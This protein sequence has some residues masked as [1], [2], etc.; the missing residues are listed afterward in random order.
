MSTMTFADIG[1]T[2]ATAANATGP[3]RLYL[4]E[5]RRTLLTEAQVLLQQRRAVL[6]EAA[7]LEKMLSSESESA[8]TED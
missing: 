2:A 5:R 6:N 8:K 4:I 3:F 7:F 1:I